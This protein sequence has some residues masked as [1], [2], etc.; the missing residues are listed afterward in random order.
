MKGSVQRAPFETSIWYAFHVARTWGKPIGYTGCAW[1]LPVDDQSTG[2]CLR[3]T[4]TLGAMDDQRDNQLTS[5]LSQGIAV[6]MW[7]MR[8]L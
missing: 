6:V 4:S 5:S 1:R 8:I 3:D 7:V 2:D